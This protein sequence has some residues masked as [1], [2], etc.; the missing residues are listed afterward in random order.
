M[1]SLFL[2]T[3]VAL[4]GCAANDGPARQEALAAVPGKAVG[5]PVTCIQQRDVDRVE[6]VNDYVAFFHM[7][8]SRV[9][10]MD[11]PQ[12]CRGLKNDAFRHSSSMAQYCRGDIIT[13]FDTTTRM[14][15]GSCGLSSF[16]PWEVPPKGE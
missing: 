14:T 3:A 6:A 13:T 12:S 15:T 11:F 1:R 7:R 5:E 2:L 4:A 16:T 10:R 8:G 9:Y